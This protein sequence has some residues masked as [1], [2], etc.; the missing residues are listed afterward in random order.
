M[1]ATTPGEP[2]LIHAIAG[3][4]RI[5]RPGWSGQEKHQLEE[6]LRQ[7]PGVQSAQANPRTR[8]VLIFF[9]PQT[10]TGKGLVTWLSRVESWLRPEG[11]PACIT[12]SPPAEGD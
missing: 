1:R 3:R 2:Q 6:M 8:N 7:A 4:A 5:H 11:L 12:A 10:I 9:D